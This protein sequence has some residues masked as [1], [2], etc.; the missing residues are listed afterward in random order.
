MQIGERV[1]HRNCGLSLELRYV[2]VGVNARQE[3]AV[4]P[5]QDLNRRR[6][7]RRFVWIPHVLWRRKGSRG[8]AGRRPRLCFGRFR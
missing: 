6:A 4:E 5:G 8:G 1:D 3:Q 7:D 2:R